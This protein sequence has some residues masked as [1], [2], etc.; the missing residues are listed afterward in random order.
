[1]VTDEVGVES[2]QTLAQ[3]ITAHLERW[4]DRT[5]IK[6]ETWALPTT[7]VEPHITR[8]VLTT[9]REALA[10]VER[11]S[12][13]ETVCVAVTVGQSGLRMT[14]SDDG[15]G[16][17]KPVRGPGIDL[18]RTAFASVGGHLDVNF[19]PGGGVT[20]TGVIPFRRR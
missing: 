18:M 19:V 9:V 8:S 1:M 5:G 14:I 17:D 10:N 20:V 15:M 11:H 4:S 7:D 16:S 2:A 3:T 12:G 6:A 13:A